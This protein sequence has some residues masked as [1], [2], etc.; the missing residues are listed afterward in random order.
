MVA[1][2]RHAHDR[3]VGRGASRKR[4]AVVLAMTLLYL[5]V[6]V[7]GALLSNS[8][9]LLADAGHMVSDVG[10]VGLALFALWYAERP[11]TPERSY[12]YAR[13]EILAALLNALVLILIV[14]YV[15]WE[16][17]GRLWD[18]PAVQS[19]PML[20]VAV[21]GLG[22][23]LLGAWILS[24]GRHDS[25]NEAGAFVHV[26]G[27]ALGSVGAIAASAIILTAGFVLADP[28]FSVL[29]SLIILWSAW[30]L[31]RRTIAV[32]MES[33]PPG[34]DLLRVRADMLRVEGVEAVHDLHIW[35]LTSGFIA[36]SAHVVASDGQAQEVL[37]R[38]RDRLHDDFGIAHTTLQIEQGEQVEEEIHCVG[39]PRCLPPDLPMVEPAR[40]GRDA[41]AL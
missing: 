38:L 24:E 16:A 39:D 18:P 35:A 27:D 25:L 33:T 28:I 7:A 34:I 32:L 19:L 20:L 29:I 12:G 31:L 11:A 4:L 41:G 9:A 15:L 5:G 40:L 21:V 10:A 8:L 2:G 1:N 22:V 6:E 17:W 37:A 36:M 13:A 26:V 3:A 30:D 14:G 23:N